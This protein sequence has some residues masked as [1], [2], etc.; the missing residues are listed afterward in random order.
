M[1]ETVHSTVY[2]D[3]T[4]RV[5]VKLRASSW[6]AQVRVWRGRRW[7]DLERTWYARTRR[8]IPWFSLD[9]QVARAVE[10]V[11]QH[12]KN[13]LTSREIQGRVNGALRLVKDDLEWLRARREKRKRR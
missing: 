5:D 4:A 1:D 3:N 11:N 9:H 6:F 13:Q 7:P 8:W 2:R 12:K 10:Y